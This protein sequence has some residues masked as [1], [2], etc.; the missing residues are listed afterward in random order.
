MVVMLNCGEDSSSRRPS[1]MPSRSIGD[2]WSERQGNRI[3]QE[4]ILLQN[5]AQT[6]M[7]PH[8]LQVRCIIIKIRITVIINIIIIIMYHL[9]SY[10]GNS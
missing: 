1:M 4:M 5:K 2:L 7:I 8:L 10:N 6:K 9:V 3:R